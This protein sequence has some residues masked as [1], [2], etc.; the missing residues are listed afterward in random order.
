MSAPTPSDLDFNQCIQGSYDESLGALR[1][2]AKIIAPIDVNG[3]V[4][5][6]IRAEDH[7]SV[8]L[9]GTLNGLPGGTVQYI[10][11]N[12]DGSL[13]VTATFAGTIGT[14]DQ[15][16]PNTLANGWPVELTDGIH[17]AS[18]NV[19]GSLNVA[20]VTSVVSNTATLSNIT[21]QVTTQVILASNPVRK[22][23]I[24]FNDSTA[25]CFIAFAATATTSAFTIFLNPT[26]T[27][28]NEAIIY[29]GIMS[30]LW[31]SANGFLRVTELI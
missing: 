28:Q 29:T 21:S 16:N 6:D 15:G 26:M 19:D 17:K 12:S 8:L 14:V 23:F 10:K 5:V 24:L 25:N 22:G 31:S 3:E 30:A 27:Y 1:T 20:N 4:L 7:D 11:V 13:N 18:V 9:A 2:T